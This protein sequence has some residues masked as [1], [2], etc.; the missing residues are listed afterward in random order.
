MQNIKNQ[1]LIKKLLIRYLAVILNNKANIEFKID[2][3]LP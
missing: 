2:I 3:K 1:C